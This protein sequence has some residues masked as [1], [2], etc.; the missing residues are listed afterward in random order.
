M[1]SN[2]SKIII[3]ICFRR[4]FLKH[5]IF[6][7]PSRIK[8]LIVCRDCQWLSMN[9]YMVLLTVLNIFHIVNSVIFKKT[10]SVNLY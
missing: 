1:T 7:L 6:V 8:V 3:N 10:G 2:T 4:L 9:R 5:W